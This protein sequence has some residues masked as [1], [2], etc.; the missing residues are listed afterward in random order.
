MKKAIKNYLRKV[1]KTSDKGYNFDSLYI[2]DNIEYDDEYFISGNKIPIVNGYRFNVKEGWRYYGPFAVYQELKIRGLLKSRDELFFQDSIGINTIMCSVEEAREVVLPYVSE[3][4]HLFLSEK[5]SDLD[6][7]PLKPEINQ[8][9]KKIKSITNNHKNRL[10][11]ENFILN[12]PHH[13]KLK[14]L[15][16]G[17]TSGGESIIAF[18]AL[19]FEAYGIDNFFDDSVEDTL[20]YEYVKKITNSKVEFKIGDITNET[21]FP[22]NYFDLI[23]SGSTIEHIK[24]LDKAF[25]E[26]FR[27]LK[28]GG[29]MIHNYDPFFHPAGGHS[30][31][32]LD[33]PWAHVRLNEEDYVQ[34]IQDNR[35][36]E[37]GISIPWIK[38]ALFSE[39][40]I[41]N[42]QSKV[43]KAGFKILNWKNKIL[44][45]NIQRDLS[46]NVI[47]D[48][49][50]VH[51]N[52]SLMDLI[53]RSVT[54]SAKKKM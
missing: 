15:E 16:I 7:R 51:P 29:I 8:V 14:V 27:I 38:K 9:K 48:A 4:S 54:F 10:L 26:M 49:F 24:D 46:Q 17:Y 45:E 19:G 35:P 6:K 22:D 33:A 23:Y 3:Y 21:E 52:L 11:N 12:R 39:H 32:I 25:Y 44:D 40:T 30:L 5:I 2:D 20:R 43:V 47:F 28:P 31:G 41:S 36:N 37:A 18:E 53:T 1:I 42:V 50:S 34:Y 13:D